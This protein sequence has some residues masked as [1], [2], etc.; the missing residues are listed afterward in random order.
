MR[1]R[2]ISARKMQEQRFKDLPIH[3]N[4]QMSS[5]ELGF[6]C[7]LSEKNRLFLET[8]A[9]KLALSAR[10]FHRIIKIARTIADLEESTS[11]TMAHLSEAVQYRSLDRERI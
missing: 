7:K 6:F 3:C 5:K 9:S 2:V 8:V 10:A 4:S 11:L 1:K